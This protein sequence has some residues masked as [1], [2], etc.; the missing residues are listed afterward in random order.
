MSK[1]EFL[2][3]FRITIWIMCIALPVIVISS[4]FEFVG[5]IALISVVVFSGIFYIVNLMALLISDNSD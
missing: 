5:G 4:F 2:K 3:I 1:K